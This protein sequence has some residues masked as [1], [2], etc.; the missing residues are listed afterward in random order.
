MIQ[1]P[2]LQESLLIANERLVDRARRR[3][4]LFRTGLMTSAAVVSVGGV[5]AAGIALWD[6]PLGHEDG[7]R[8]SLSS[9][10]VPAEQRA[11]LGVLR[12]EQTAADRTAVARRAL[13]VLTRPYQGIRL[14]ALRV[15]VQG[16]GDDGIVLASVADLQ[17]RTVVPATA[18]KDALCVYLATGPDSSTK[19]FGLT[20]VRRGTATG[21]TGD[22][23]WVLLPD[24]VARVVVHEPGG[25]DREVPVTSNVLALDAGEVD[26]R[27]SD[28]RWLA[29]DGSDVTP[30]GALPLLVFPE[31]R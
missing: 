9:T 22:L 24:G 1:L 13:T 30:N 18:A 6:P 31:D 16:P 8:P 27:A 7:N 11:V 28:L 14:D 26:P 12:R 19:C 21:R 25:A 23:V 10:P 4:R 15:V 29:Q 17:P 3:A 20:D 2:Q 5:A